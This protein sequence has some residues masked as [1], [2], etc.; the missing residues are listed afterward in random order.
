M[1]GLLLCFAPPFDVLGLWSCFISDRLVLIQLLLVS[2][3]SSFTGWGTN[4]PWGLLNLIK[5]PGTGSGS[6]SGVIVVRVQIRVVETVVLENGVFVP[7]PER[8]A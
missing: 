7:Y 3:L 5:G 4:Y 6:G 8:V 2:P 1:F